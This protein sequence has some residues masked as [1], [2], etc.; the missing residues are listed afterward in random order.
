M[1][2]HGSHDMRDGECTCR[3]CSDDWKDL[4]ANKSVVLFEKK[5]EGFESLADIDRDVSEAFDGDFN[6]PAE[7]LL[8]EFQG[9][10]TVTITYTPKIFL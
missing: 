2:P 4:T 8:G 6:P 3:R 9:T 10:V 7:V 1:M 5:Y